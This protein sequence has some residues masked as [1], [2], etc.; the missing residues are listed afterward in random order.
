MSNIFLSL[1]ESSRNQ[2]KYFLFSFH[3]SFRSWDIPI[4]EAVVQKFSVKK[5][6][7]KISQK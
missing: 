2:E 6:F 1:K 7:L 5:V 3:G 4:S